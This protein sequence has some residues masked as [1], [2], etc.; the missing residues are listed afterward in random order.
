MYS[1]QV[2]EMFPSELLASMWCCFN[3]QCFYFDTLFKPTELEWQQR[4][5]E[6]ERT[7]VPV[8]RCPSCR[9]FMEVYTDAET[10]NL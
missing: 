7:L 6:V 5:C 10:T 3:I 9:Q 2:A 1:R 4:W 8:P